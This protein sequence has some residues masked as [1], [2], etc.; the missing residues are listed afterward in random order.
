MEEEWKE[1]WL[2]TNY[3]VS[4]L[5]RV[6]SIDRLVYG[7]KRTFR[8][9][10]GKILTPSTA[11]RGYLFVTIHN[12]ITNTQVYP[13]VARLVAIAFIPNPNNLPQ[14][15]HKDGIKTNNVATNLEWCTNRENKAHS[16]KMKLSAFGER[17]GMAK[18]T[19]RIVYSIR[20]EEYNIPNNVLGKKYGVG[21]GYINKI[22]KKQCWQC[23]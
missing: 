5:G 11:N 3:L 7:K 1:T 20:N 9:V 21:T 13:K 19:E 22:K 12:N 18:L 15:N 10:K 2:N 14:V 17:N 23:V 16:A 6:K 8:H 4:T